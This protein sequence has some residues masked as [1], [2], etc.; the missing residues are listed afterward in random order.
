M[1]ADALTSREPDDRALWNEA[2]EAMHSWRFDPEQFAP[3]DRPDI[4][5]LEAAIDYAVD[6]LEQGAAAPSSI[7]PSGSGRVAFEWRADNETMIVDFVGRGE[8]V[9]THFVGGRVVEKERLVSDPLTRRLEP[10]G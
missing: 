2:L 10:E 3:E 9:L 4:H 5:I 7:V 8:A 1:P 6:Q